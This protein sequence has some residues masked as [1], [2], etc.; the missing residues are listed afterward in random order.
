MRLWICTVF[1]LT[2]CVTTPSATFDGMPPT[3]VADQIV[4]VAGAGPAEQEWIAQ[5][6]RTPQGLTVVFLDAL[7]ARPV[8]RAT[9]GA[10][11]KVEWL[12]PVPDP[13]KAV[14]DP[15]LDSM[16]TLFAHRFGAG[17]ERHEVKTDAGVYLLEDFQGPPDCRYPRM[18][19]LTPNQ[20]EVRVSIETQ[21][22][23]CEGLP[24]G[25]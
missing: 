9:K 18:M 25:E 24:D 8:L 21:G 5:V 20:G 1:G 3:F 17:T 16:V 6:A 22:L 11:T 15:M 19:T 4:T 13:A 12:A 14:A 10:E 23:T 2:A 7:T